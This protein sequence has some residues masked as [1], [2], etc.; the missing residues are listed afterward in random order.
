M[1]KILLLGV[2][3]VALSL[4]ACNQ[5]G[6]T[7]QAGV[8][9]TWSKVVSSG[10]GVSSFALPSTVKSFD[11]QT[12]FQSSPGD[13]TAYWAFTRNGKE[14]GRLN[15]AVEGDQ[16]S[17]TISYTY[18]KGE[19]AGEDE[20]IEQVI[21]QVAQPLFVEAVDA[22]IEDRARDET[23][24]SVADAESTKLLIGQAV[25][26]SYSAINEARKESDARWAAREQELERLDAELR[27]ESW[28]EE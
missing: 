8:D 6:E 9:A 17:S 12:N 22:A 27:G 2:T 20:K 28:G 3:A 23:L 4:S 21:R 5:P 26:E 1:R 24:K 7:Y 18:A 10:Y 19:V 13:R 15:V 11:V 16:A 25:K 14:L